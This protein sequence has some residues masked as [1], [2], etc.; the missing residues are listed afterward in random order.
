[1]FTIHDN[2]L[3]YIGQHM[4]FQ[5]FSHQKAASSE[6][7]CQSFCCSHTQSMDV[8]EG[9]DK[10]FR[11]LALLDISAWAFIGCIYD[12]LGVRSLHTSIAQNWKFTMSLLQYRYRVLLSA[13]FFSGFK[14]EISGTCA[15]Y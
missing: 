8:D 13:S 14:A 3:P 10:K 5:Y 6:Q 15:Y 7:T 9:P 2:F 11:L 1:M 12:E 4:K